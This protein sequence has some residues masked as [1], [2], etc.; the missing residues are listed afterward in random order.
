M[1][2]LILCLQI[3]LKMIAFRLK[4]F[5]EKFEV[6]DAIIIVISWTIDVASLYVRL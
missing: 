1:K 5:L 6:F 2:T 4:H 3:V